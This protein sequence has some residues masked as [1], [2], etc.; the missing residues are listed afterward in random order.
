MIGGLSMV[1]RYSS[2]SIKL[3]QSGY[4]DSLSYAPSYSDHKE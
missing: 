3:I 4:R 2:Q 1:M